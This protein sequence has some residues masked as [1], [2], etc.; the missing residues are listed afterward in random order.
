MLQR[1]SPPHRRSQPGFDHLSHSE[2]LH[3]QTLMT[4][5]MH[6]T[7]PVLRMEKEFLRNASSCSTP[8]RQRL[9]PAE[10]PAVLGGEC[11]SLVDQPW[12]SA[13]HTK[14]AGEKGF[15]PCSTKWHFKPWHKHFFSLFFSAH[16]YTNTEN[17]SRGHSHGKPLGGDAQVHFGS[18]F[19][20]LNTLELLK[21]SL[22]RMKRCK[23]LTLS[24]K[25]SK[26]C[27][28]L[29]RLFSRRHFL[30]LSKGYFPWFYK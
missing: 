14:H 29:K 4:M 12:T 30:N 18:F 7:D 2:T 8:A 15:G 10:E 21:F 5:T 9:S 17:W 22:L 24:C 27:L 6:V 26:Q 1:P 20:F 11:P 13:V 23:N 16:F 28:F 19:F 25:C 3:I